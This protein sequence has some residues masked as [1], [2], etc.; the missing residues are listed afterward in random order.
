MADGCS[1]PAEHLRGEGWIK[2]FNTA[3]EFKNCNRQ[4]IL[5]LAGRNVSFTPIQSN[6]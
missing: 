6:S 4:K 3:E 5:E 1:V 2:N